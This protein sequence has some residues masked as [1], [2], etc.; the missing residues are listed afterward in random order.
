[1]EEYKLRK[2]WIIVGVLGVA[3]LALGAAGLAYAQSETPPP[4]MNPGYGPGMMGGR[5]RHGGGLANGEESLYH[6]S[7]LES[8]AEAL[9]IAIDQLEARLESGEMMWQIA[10]EE[11][12]SEEEIFDIVQQG[13]QAMVEQAVEDG[14]LS[15]EQAEFMGPRWQEGGFRG[16]YGGCMGYGYS[17][18]EGYHRGPQGRWYA[19]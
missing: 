10:E 14:I 2:I 16:G 15:Q 12:V 6:E 5:V 9:G 1:L 18:E 3:A 4:F 17:N 13:R 19:P 11:G 8:F 7:M